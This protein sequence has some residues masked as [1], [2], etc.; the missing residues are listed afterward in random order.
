MKKRRVFK[1]QPRAYDASN[2]HQ[3]ARFIRAD[4]VVLTWVGSERQAQFFNKSFFGLRREL[5]AS[6]PFS[7][8][9]VLEELNAV[10]NSEPPGLT[11]PVVNR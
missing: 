2:V 10:D 7:Y 3:K 6:C 5:V 11:N 4:T 1:I 9:Y 8:N